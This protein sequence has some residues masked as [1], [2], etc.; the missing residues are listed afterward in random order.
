MPDVGRGQRRR[1]VD[2]VADHRDHVRRR[3]AAPARRAALSPGSTS[4]RT[5]SMPSSLR[6]RLRRCRGCRRS[7]SRSGCPAA[8]SR[9]DGLRARRLDGV[10]EGQQPEQLGVAAAR[11][12]PA[13]RPSGPAPRSACASRGQRA[14]LDAAARAAAGCCRAR[15]LRPR[16]RPS[17]PRPGSACASSAAGNGTPLARGRCPAPRAPADVRSCCCSAAARR[18]TSSRRRPGAG[19]TATSAGRPSVSVP[20]LSKATVVTA[21]ATSSACGV[22]DQD[23]VARRDAGAGHDRRRRGQAQRAGAGDHQHRHR[24]DQRLLPVAAGRQPSRRSVSSAI[25]EHHR[26]EHRADP[27]DEALDRRLG[28]LRRLD[29]PDDARQRGLGADRQRRARVSSA[30]GVDRAA[31]HAVAGRLGHR[32]AF[33]GDQRLVDVAAALDDLAVDRRRARPGRTT[34]RSPTRDLLDRHVDARRRR[35]ARARSS[36]A[37]RSARGSRRRSAAWRGLPATCRAAPA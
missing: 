29:Q 21:C 37:A 31:G 34:T 35:G 22:L 23:A 12:A 3:R 25:T 4:A 24:V 13:R 1:V 9:A 6:H 19:T 14:R 33:A 10:A 5:S 20:V 18:S 7:A 30:F 2:A 26:H 32:Q 27:V 28:R 8:C 36:G 16:P 15:A 17:T 11:C